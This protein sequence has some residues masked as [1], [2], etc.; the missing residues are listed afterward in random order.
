MGTGPRSPEP[1][2]LPRR[3]G[4]V[5]DGSHF[6]QKTKSAGLR[7]RQSVG[8]DLPRTS[9]DATRARQGP[10]Q[11][12]HALPQYLPLVGHA[13]VDHEEDVQ[14]IHV[15]RAEYLS[16]LG[17]ALRL[18]IVWQGVL[19]SSHEAEQSQRREPFIPRFM[20]KS[21]SKQYSPQITPN[22]FRVSTGLTEVP[23]LEPSSRS[24]YVPGSLGLA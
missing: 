14:L 3:P 7:W 6:S 11:G 5:I 15:V 17:D 16:E 19:A 10:Q 9:I 4:S 1:W 13:V 21:Y 23:T 20:C 12:R 22:L 2:R 8:L 18:C 24:A